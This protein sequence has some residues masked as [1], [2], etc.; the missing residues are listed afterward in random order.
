M[1][2]P[3]TKVDGQLN[4]DVVNRQL[5]AFTCPSMPPPDN[6]VFNCWSSYGWSR[7]NNDIHDAPQPGDIIWPGKSYGYV[8]SDGAFVTA[9]DLGYTNDMGTAD[10][11][12]HTGQSSWWKDPSDYRLSFRN[13][14]DGMSKTLAAGELHHGIQGFTSTKINSVTVGSATPSSGFTA[15]GADNGDYFDEGT[16][17]VKMNTWV[18]TLLCSR[19]VGSDLRNCMFNSP[20]FSFRSTHQRWL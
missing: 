5:S 15:W 2:R 3:V 13:F 20:N 1:R 12:A 8:P 9:V 11:A 17:N 4:I 16:T 7:G 10:K 14:S 6:P 19:N 18:G